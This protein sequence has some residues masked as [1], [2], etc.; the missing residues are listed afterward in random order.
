MYQAWTDE[1]FA[2]VLGI[3]LVAGQ[4]LRPDAFAVRL[5]GIRFDRTERSGRYRRLGYA[6]AGDAVG[7]DLRSADGSN[8]RGGKKKVET[9]HTDRRRDQG[10][11]TTASLHEPIAPLA[12][13]PDHEGGHI[14]AQ[15]RL[16]GNLA[17]GL[18]A[19]RDAWRELNPDFAFE[20]T[21]VDQTFARLYESEQ[22]FAQGLRYLSPRWPSPSL[23]WASSAL[24]PSP[25]KGVP[26]RLASERSWARPFLNRVPPA[27]QRVLLACRRSQRDRLAHCL[28]CHVPLAGRFLLPCR[29]GL[30]DLLPGWRPRHGDRPVDRELPGTSGRPRPPI[31]SNLF[32]Q[33]NKR[34][35]PTRTSR[36]RSHL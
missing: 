17:E 7:H 28:R 21:F 20:Y 25:R 5:A 24:H 11:T 30:D 15:S 6:S 27:V 36:T 13:F 34:R 12:L 3:E 2:D 14:L 26:G 10:F 32:A 35:P 18:A 9:Q 29:P 19:I 22:R 1:D 33:L 23:A 4:V 31:R 8:G 16:P